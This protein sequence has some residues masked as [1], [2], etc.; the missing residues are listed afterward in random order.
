ML[1]RCGEA[2]ISVK[3]RLFSGFYEVST[4]FNKLISP[5]RLPV[6]RSVLGLGFKGT[7][8]GVFVF[9]LDE[10]PSAFLHGGGVRAH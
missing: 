10:P 2:S 6:P 1:S 5:S 9:S 3:R 8:V 7:N 4:S